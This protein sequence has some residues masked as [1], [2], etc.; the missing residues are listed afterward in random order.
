MKLSAW[1][2][3]AASSLLFAAL[4]ANAETRPQ[5]GGTLHVSFREAPTSLDPADTTQPDSFAQRNLTSLIFETLVTTDRHGRLGPG[6]A[7]GWMQEAVGRSQSWHLRLRTGV[8]LH[9]NTLLTPAIAAASLRIANPSWKIISDADAI[10]LECDALCYQLPEELALPRNAIIKRTDDG[11]QIGTGPFHVAEWQPGKKLVLAAEE[12][13]WAGRPFLDAIEFEFGKSFREQLVSLELGKAD[14]IEIS[15]EQAHRV[16]MTSHRLWSSQP[17]ELVALVFAHEAQSAEEK[18]LREALALCIER[19]SIGS[20]IL[21]GSGLPAVGVLPNWMN[22]YGFVFSTEADLPRA[23][24]LQEEARTTRPWLISYDASDPIAGLLAE[25]IALNA[26]DAGLPL[27]PT[28]A[29]AADLRLARIPL[30]SDPALALS[31]VAASVG[32][33][34]PQINSA[35]AEDLY[36]S[37]R[38]LLAKQ[39]LI[40]LFHLPVVYAGSAALQDWSPQADGRWNLADAWLFH[41]KAETTNP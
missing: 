26:R 33:P 37:E 6:L 38:E 7:T 16:S 18:S 13:Y 5:Y 20:V 41:E 19:A 34:S 4:G 32:L 3:L 12:N 17:V 27:Q 24:R 35:S 39:M 28:K 22:G 31:L 9:D 8:K 23:R 11:K 21:Q 25:R 14:L 2:W 10:T 36:S 15:A 1:Q 29:A 40:P 30:P